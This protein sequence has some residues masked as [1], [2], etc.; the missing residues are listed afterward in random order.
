MT[1]SKRF[2]ET[3][4]NAVAVETP[5]AAEIVRQEAPSERR[6]IITRGSAIFLGLPKRFPFALA[7]RRPA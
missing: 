6:R 3:A 7:F 4:L 1:I 5:S 2:F